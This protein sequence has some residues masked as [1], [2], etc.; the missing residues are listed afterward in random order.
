VASARSWAIH[1]GEES[2][3]GNASYETIPSA[4]STASQHNLLASLTSGAAQL[5]FGGRKG[6]LSDAPTSV[7]TVTGYDGSQASV[8]YRSLVPVELYTLDPTEGVAS[9]QV[10]RPQGVSS[11]Q[12]GSPP[13]VTYTTTTTVTAPT[14]T[15]QGQERP[16]PA[17]PFTGASSS[18]DGNPKRPAGGDGN[19]D[20]GKEP[21]RGVHSSQDGGPTGK[22][23]HHQVTHVTTT[24]KIL[25]TTVRH[26]ANDGTA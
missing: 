11:T 9:T 20:G 13:V 17:N 5:L 2:S 25:R 10:G 8:P 22:G 18:Q 6:P 19:G 4:S 24:R 14:K 7:P 12:V 26:Q 16:P 1:G 23:P 3:G 21:P 15:V